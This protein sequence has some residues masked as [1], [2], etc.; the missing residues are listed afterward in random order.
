MRR[1]GSHCSTQFQSS[2]LH[3]MALETYFKGLRYTHEDDVKLVL[4]LD[5]AAGSTIR[6]RQPLDTRS[7]GDIDRRRSL[8]MVH[9]RNDSWNSCSQSLTESIDS[10]LSLLEKHERGQVDMEE[11]VSPGAQRR[12][13]DRFNFDIAGGRAAPPMSMLSP[14]IPAISCHSSQTSVTK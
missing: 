5:N 7:F 9:G 10:A 11:F 3:A 8:P 12:P 6:T 13:T 2:Y 14:A 1:S 4:I